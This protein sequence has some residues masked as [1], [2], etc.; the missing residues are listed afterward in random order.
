[1]G[2]AQVARDDHE[3]SVAGSIL[4]AGEFHRSVGH[5]ARL[6]D[7]PLSMLMANARPP[8]RRRRR[9]H[10]RV[11]LA[12]AV[13]ALLLHAAVLDGDAVGVA[14]NAV[15]ANVAAVTVRTLEPAVPPPIELPPIAPTTAVLAPPR[16]TVAKRNA[17]RMPVAAP[18]EAGRAA[19]P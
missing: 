17:V 15:E 5:G 11:L 7:P 1:M 9:L 18:A 14:G 13:L 12:A 8:A 3:L 2:R 4:V 19:A 16:P 10:A 6:S